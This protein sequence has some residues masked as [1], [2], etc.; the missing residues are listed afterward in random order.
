MPNIQHLEHHLLM[1][2]IKPIKK[3]YKITG[4]CFQAM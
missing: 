4:K 2:V 3:S 1:Q